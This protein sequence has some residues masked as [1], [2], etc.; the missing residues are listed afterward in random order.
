MRC[1][2]TSA[3][4]GDA[5]WACRRRPR[6]ARAVA[7]IVLLAMALSTSTTLGVTDGPVGFRVDLR[8]IL[9]PGPVL[10]AATSATAFV[11]LT[12]FVTQYVGTVNVGSPPQTLS[13]LFDT[14]SADF[15]VMSDKCHPG[16]CHD[17]MASM[18]SFYPQ[19]SSTFTY[20]VTSWDSVLR[21]RG[22]LTS[23]LHYG[24]GSVT[25]QIGQDW[26][27]FGD[28]LEL[29][30]Q[31]TRSLVTRDWSL[32]FVAWMCLTWMLLFARWC[33]WS[34]LKVDPCPTLWPTVL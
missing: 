7:V 24:S 2:W 34:T 11:P 17:R 22:P 10:N 29:E 32:W 31:V 14:G 26:V 9:E 20:E 33:C 3:P 27:R 23:T 28:S 5:L 15:W 6:C 21:P 4:R 30:N 19:R 16:T 13:V 8:P 1:V 18:A 25:G 12:S